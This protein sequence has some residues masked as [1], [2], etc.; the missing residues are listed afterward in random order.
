MPTERLE[1]PVPADGDLRD[2]PDMPMGVDVPQSRFYAIAT[3]EEF[4]AGFS[5]LCRAWHQLPA[6][7][8]PSDDR[9]LALLAGVGRDLA[10][11]EQ[12]K[13]GALYGWSKYKD[14]RLYHSELSAR[15]MQA[16]ASKKRD[17]KR[18]EAARLARLEKQ[19]VA[20]VT[21]D[22]TTPAAEDVAEADTV[23]VEG[24]PLHPRE[25]K[26]SEGKKDNTLSGNSSASPPQPDELVLAQPE[27]PLD[28]RQLAGKTSN[29]ALE[30]DAIAVLEHFNARAKRNFKP[31]PSTLRP[32]I[33]RLREDV[34]IEE[35]NFVARAK[36]AEWRDD[37]RMAKYVRPKTIFGDN[38]GNYLGAAGPVKAEGLTL[39][40]FFAECK[41]DP[42][43][44]NLEPAV[45]VLRQNGLPVQQVFAA[46]RVFVDR[47]MDET[48]LEGPFTSSDWPAL[49]ARLILDPAL[50]AY[51][52]LEGGRYAL[53]PK[54]RAA[55]ET[56]DLERKDPL[57]QPKPWQYERRAAV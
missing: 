34:S 27:N 38:F 9:E 20:N 37:A 54:G 28:R 10:K 17:S 48:T 55:A 15:V 43:R 24:L 21:D 16:L 46:W 6:G 2:Y 52:R 14:G 36:I 25:V 53:A 3:P 18:T 30:A 19:R 51:E 35:L 49:L 44:F 50:G 29:A 56:I 22:V 13:T 23:S 47:Y 4:M 31:L 40:Q 39:R 45:E 8:L 57:T 41:R 1:P 26:G 33:A 42:T 11:W 7:S 32:I 12:I 5:L